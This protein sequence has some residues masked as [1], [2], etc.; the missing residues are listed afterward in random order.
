MF[1]GKIPYQYGGEGIQILDPKNPPKNMDC[2]AF[3]ASIYLTKFGIKLP[4]TTKE[5]IKEGIEVSKEELKIGDLIFFDW[6]DPNT[7]K[8]D[9]IVDHVGIY[10]GN[11]QYIDEGGTGEKANVRICNLSNASSSVLAVRR[12]IQDYGTILN[13]K[14]PEV[15]GDGKSDITPIQKLD[16]S[17]EIDKKLYDTSKV[18]AHEVDLVNQITSVNK[19]KFKWDIDNFKRIYQGNKETYERISEKTGIPPELIAAL[20]YR[21]SGCNF[22]TYLHNGQK[23]GKTTTI[24]PKGIYFEDFTEAAID[25]LSRKSS[26]RDE[27]Q[28][29]FDCNDIAKMMAFAERY[30]GL[31][32]YNKK[33]VSPYVYSGTNVYTGGKYVSDG[34][35]DSNTVDKQPGVYILI[36]AIK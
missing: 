32:Y 4:R 26:V 20:H 9:G 36:D 8:R 13:N 34:V 31:G 16:S 15:K 14:L 10:I 19:E 18:Y 12:I 7:G 35:Y 23:L 2:S 11:G 3:V 28:L 24:V 30:N 1:K 17:S 27:F 22:N 6:K 33:R 21:E 29:T 5:Q 25:A